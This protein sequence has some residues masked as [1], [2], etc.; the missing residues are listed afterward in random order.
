MFVTLDTDVAESMWLGA[1]YLP[2]LIEADRAPTPPRSSNSPPPCPA[3]R[4]NRSRCRRE[5]AG[6]RADPPVPQV[7]D[8]APAPGNGGD[9]E[10]ALRDLEADLESGEWDR[11][12]GDLRALDELDVGLRLVHVSLKRVEPG[13]RARLDFIS[14]AWLCVRSRAGWALRPRRAVEHLR[15]I[16]AGDADDDV[17]DV[18]ERPAPKSSTFTCSVEQADYP[19]VESASTI[20]QQATGSNRLIIS[21]SSSLGDNAE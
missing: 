8:L 21:I 18:G 6:P 11:R 9:P 14:R 12:H 16:E 15:D 3:S 13:P 5:R 19:P 10:C 2:E 4:S 20:S 7:V 1:E 17:D